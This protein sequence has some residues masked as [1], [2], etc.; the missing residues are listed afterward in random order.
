VNLLLSVAVCI[1]FALNVSGQ[2]T[3]IWNAPTN[4]IT[5]NGLGGNGPISGAGNY[6]FGL[7]VGSPGSLAGSFSL[8]GLAVN[9]NVPGSYPGQ[10]GIIP[11]PFGAG[12][13]AIQV[14]A[15]SAFAGFSYEEALTYALAGNNP[16]AFLGQSTVD[17]YTIG[18]PV[19]YRPAAFELTPVPEPSTF[20]F[21]ILGAATLLFGIRSRH[22]KLC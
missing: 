2:G 16:I 14:R 22:K 17:T 15:W 5:T 10:N 20:A 6:K 9:G 7:Y 19:P 13:I 4:S 3:L 8:V 1:L 12:T 11:P 18:S 21:T